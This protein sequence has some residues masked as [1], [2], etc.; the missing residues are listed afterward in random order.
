MGFQTNDLKWNN[1]T[2]LVTTSFNWDSD[3]VRTNYLSSLTLNPYYPWGFMSF[4]R[5]NIQGYL[6]AWFLIH[7]WSKTID[8]KSRLTLNT[9]KHCLPGR[10]PHCQVENHVQRKFATPILYAIDIFKFYDFFPS[11]YRERKT[12]VS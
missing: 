5:K 2:K 7:L 9:W 11:I 12:S 6:H 10:A 4:S 8:I 1:Y 3:T